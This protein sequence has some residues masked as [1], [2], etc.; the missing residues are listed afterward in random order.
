MRHATCTCIEEMRGRGMW[1]W[2]FPNESSLGCR[3]KA[4]EPSAGRLVL[5]RR[6][7]RA[8]VQS[9]RLGAR[10]SKVARKASK[11]RKDLKGWKVVSPLPLIDKRK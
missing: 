11:G 5:E 8:R 7:Q 10:E 3:A 9:Q 4:L 1:V 2:A 6:G